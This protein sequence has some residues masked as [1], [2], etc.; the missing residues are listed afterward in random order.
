MADHHVAG[1][2]AVHEDLAHELLGGEAGQVQGIFHHQDGVQAQLAQ[3]FQLVL[4]AHDHLGRRLRPVDHGRVRIK[5][6]G[7]GFNAV[8]SGGPDQ[9][10]QHLLVAAV[11]AV[12][13]AESDNGWTEVRRDLGRIVPDVDHHPRLLLPATDMPGRLTGAG[14]L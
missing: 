14:T 2:E 8:A 3:R 7:Y 10:G 13:V 9:L 4:Q 11:D 12:E 5:G 1:V 6:D